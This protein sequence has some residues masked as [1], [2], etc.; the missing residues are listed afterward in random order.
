MYFWYLLIF[1]IEFLKILKV[2]SYF[3]VFSLLL[4]LYALK[5][6]Q[7]LFSYHAATAYSGV[8]ITKIGGKTAKCNI[9]T[10]IY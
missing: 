2:C 3:N 4:A 7:D 10:E 9:I 8:E 1:F 5:I 6:L